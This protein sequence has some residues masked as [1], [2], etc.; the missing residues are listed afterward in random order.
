MTSVCAITAFFVRALLSPICDKRV[1]KKICILY[2][3]TIILTKVTSLLQTLF[4][5]SSG[6]AQ[7]NVQEFK[8]RIPTRDPKKSFHIM[9][10]NSSL[11]V[12]TTKWSQVAIKLITSFAKF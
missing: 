11:R 10:F 5:M 6:G 12:D 1:A 8:V 7:E 9:K 3:P 2:L 4:A